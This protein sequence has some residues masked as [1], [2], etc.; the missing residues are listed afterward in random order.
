V[1]QTI[2]RMPW[3]NY[4]TFWEDKAKKNNIQ[5]H[6]TLW[7]NI[8]FQTSSRNDSLNS[9][10][11]LPN[12]DQLHRSPAVPQINL[13]SIHDTD[14]LD[15]TPLRKHGLVKSKMQADDLPQLQ[16]PYLSKSDNHNI[17]RDRTPVIS[18][19]RNILLSA[20]RRLSVGSESDHFSDQVEE[21]SLVDDDSLASIQNQ[22]EVFEQMKLSISQIGGYLYFE[23]VEYHLQQA[24]GGTLIQ[25][26]NEV[27]KVEPL[28]DQNIIGKVEPVQKQ[29]RT[30]YTSPDPSI[31]SSFELTS[32]HIQSQKDQMDKIRLEIRRAC[33]KVAAE[34]YKNAMVDVPDVSGLR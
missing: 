9:F 5:P 12:P 11:D 31:P 17:T 18:P 4:D 25:D 27:I 22:Q 19:P 7:V 20:K 2:G 10:L 6:R 34:S 24:Q 28:E 15:I 13:R 33:L 16:I 1:H 32:T 8:E 21:D 3:P 29:N 26:Q 30:N 14:S 23:S